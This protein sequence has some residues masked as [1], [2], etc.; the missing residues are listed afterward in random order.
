M[1]PV[2]VQEHFTDGPLHGTCVST[3]TFHDMVPV[4]LQNQH[5]TSVTTR[6]P[7]TMVLVY[8]QKHFSTWFSSYIVGTYNNSSQHDT[9]V[10][11]PLFSSRYL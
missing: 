10:P 8:L 9:C 5:V 1:V 4:Y 6:T 11:V 2:Y 7:N 3:R